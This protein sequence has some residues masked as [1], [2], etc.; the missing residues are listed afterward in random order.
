MLSEV[1]RDW[2]VALCFVFTVSLSI[3]QYS[4]ELNLLACHF[5]EDCGTEVTHLLHAPD[6]QTAR[7]FANDHLIKYIWLAVPGCSLLFS[8]LWKQQECTES[9]EKLSFSHDC[10]FKD[11][12]QYLSLHII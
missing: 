10:I 4:F 12:K 9:S 1:C 11:V 3:A 8:F 5:W 6:Q 2:N 7:F